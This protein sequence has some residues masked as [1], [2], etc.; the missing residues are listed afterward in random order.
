MPE[1]ASFGRSSR[2]PAFPRTS[3]ATFPRASSAVT[4]EGSSGSCGLVSAA[5]QA[6]AACEGN[7]WG[8]CGGEESE[9]VR[10]DWLPV[11]SA[12]GVAGLASFVSSKLRDYRGQMRGI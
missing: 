5:A 10:S 9:V 8:E 12:E 1:L 6:P 2:L 7:P 3:V 11:Q 4:D